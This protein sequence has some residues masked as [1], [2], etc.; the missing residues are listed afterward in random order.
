[1]RM[2]PAPEPQALSVLFVVL[3]LNPG[4]AERMAIEIIRRLAPRVPMAVCCLDE[5]G[6]W[7]GEIA[8]LG[9]EV[10]ALHRRPGF[11]PSLGSRIA[12]LARARQATVLHCHQYT[13][14]VYGR[15]AALRQRGL[16]VVFTEHGRLSDSAPSTKRK[17]VNQ[18][19]GRLPA[20]IYSVSEDLK[21]H[22]IREGFSTQRVG[23]IHNGIEP[24]VAPTTADREA[25]RRALGVAL[26][27]FLVGTVARLDPV[28]DIATLVQAITRVRVD[29]PRAELVIVGDGPERQYLEQAVMRAG[30]SRAVHFSGHRSDI[31]QLLPALDVYANSSI[32]E[33]ISLTILEAMASC[34]P[35]VATRVGGTPEVVTD[36]VTGLLVPA[37]APELLA[38]ALLALARDPRRGTAFGLSARHLVERCFSVDVMVEKYLRAYVAVYSRRSDH[39]LRF[40]SSAL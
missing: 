36:L 10:I 37:R 8:N 6:A 23:V 14:F 3:S 11:H 38:R 22:M 21:R 9:V 7:A 18:V 27:V 33:G 25:A 40:A 28:K 34:L 4:G 30:V 5:M 24:G 20:R 13:P 32:S 17:V 29:V 31:R 2:A 12:D 19:L 1:M 16:G 15:I 35:V 39:A 26:D